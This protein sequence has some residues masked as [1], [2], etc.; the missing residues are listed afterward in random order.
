MGLPTRAFVARHRRIA[1]LA[2][3]LFLVLVAGAVALG[4]TGVLSNQTPT[5]FEGLA[6]V[7]PTDPQ[8]HFPA[9]YR[10]R[11][12]TS[13]EACVD[14]ADANCIAPAGAHFDPAKPLSLESTDPAANNFPDE[15][16]YFDS[17]SVTK[18]AGPV[19]RLLVE[20]NLEGAFANGAPALGDQMAFS[21]FRVKVDDGLKP[22]TT[23]TIVHPYGTADVT[24]DPRATGF[25]VT[26]GVPLAPLA[27]AAALRSRLGPFLAWDPTVAPAA[28]AGYL[29][30][31]AINHQV[32]GSPVG[33]NYVALLGPGVSAGAAAANAC[34]Q[35]VLDKFS[36]RL[37]GIVAAAPAGDAAA[38]RANDCLYNDLFS[39]M[40]KKATRSGVDVNRATYTRAAD[41]TTKL[42]VLAESTADQKI[43][44]QDPDPALRAT[45]NR[46]FDA[47]LLSGANGE[48]FAH[49][50]AKA[51]TD[52]VEV[53]NQSDAP[54]TVKDVPLVDMI[55]GT[56]VYDGATAGPNLHVVAK[57]SDQTAA[58]QLSVPTDASGAPVNDPASTIAQVLSAQAD[59]TQ[60]FG[61]RVAAPPA[62]VVVRSAQG[63]TVELPV[64]VTK[65][66]DTPA[67]PL[68]AEAGADK[69]IVNGPLEPAGVSVVGSGS[70]GNITAYEWTGP[71]AVA[72][73]QLTGAPDPALGA[74]PVANPARPSDATIAPPTAVGDY[75]YRL[76]VTGDPGATDF[77]DM[78]LTVGA[79]PTAADEVITPGKQRYTP[80]QRRWVVDGTDTVIAGNSITV[81]NGS[82]ATGQVIGT[83]PI[84]TVGG[85]LVD[86]RD[87]SILPQRCTADPANDCVTLVSKLGT[88]LTLVVDARKA[89]APA[90]VAPAAGAGGQ[91]APV[92]PVVA[93]A[94]IAPAP[95]RAARVAPV[96]PFAATALVGAGVPLTVTV[97]ARAR[98]LR[99][100]V[101]TVPARA[102]A[103]R[104]AATGRVIFRGFR[105]VTAATKAHTVRFRL[106]SR[107]LY[108]RVR[109]AHR[110]VLEVTPGLSRT[111]LGRPTGT[112]FRVK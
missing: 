19:T 31:P 45:A 77:D 28:P 9:W 52:K 109:A 76:T 95:L 38:T 8:L 54:A 20:N 49:I 12:G 47:T 44:A 102:R 107:K 58:A 103:A 112:V 81:H 50:P 101:L 88:T 62:T 26:R 3:A 34:P 94:P 60:T 73:G 7:G 111:R 110:Y 90:A 22:S 13:L 24:T 66:P 30:D 86:V 46:R 74:A 40:G 1:G 11:Q 104:T 4:P 108:G 5:Q 87:S 27:F 64:D 29:G 99:L 15:F 57:S 100:R 105:A 2:A 78:I 17:T 39:L 69:S 61:L 80:A 70:T 35:A 84:D 97:P 96:A 16:F 91:A 51:L 21:R 6:K 92:A 37:D 63:G 18:N 56:V 79:G 93:P 98:V 65:A 32:T 14:A 67:A 106:R 68:K 82:S 75:G 25:F 36:A 83:S 71:Y 43:V 59:G 85:Y 72:G 53:V 42:E 55:S 33:T 89:A 41:G 10:D 48:Y 23:Y